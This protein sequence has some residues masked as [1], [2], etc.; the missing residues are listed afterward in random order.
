MRPSAPPPSPACAPVRAALAAN[1]ACRPFDA[2][3]RDG[4][5]PGGRASASARATKNADLTRAKCPDAF[6]RAR[7]ELKLPE[8][9]PARNG[10]GMKGG[11]CSAL[12]D[13][14]PGA[15]WSAWSA[16]GA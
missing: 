16:R 15:P 8:E 2:G 4:N 14:F 7:D 3:T 12:A 13:M 1:R 10:I 9:Q 11:R 5:A 6:A